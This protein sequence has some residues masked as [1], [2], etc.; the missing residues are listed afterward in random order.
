MARLVEKQA[1]KKVM[2]CHQKLLAELAAARTTD[3][4]LRRLFG[5]G[6]S[7]YFKNR[8]YLYT[9]GLLSPH[10]RANSLTFSRPSR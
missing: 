5:C 2:R 1:A 7:F 3:E 9:V 4:K 8:R 10:T 6:N